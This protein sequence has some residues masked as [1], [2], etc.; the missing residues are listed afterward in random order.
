MNPR[1]SRRVM[2][3]TRD[4]FGTQIRGSC[5][6]QDNIDKGRDAIWEGREGW[7]T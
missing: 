1:V 7:H 6:P 4:D 5:I 2:P 3:I